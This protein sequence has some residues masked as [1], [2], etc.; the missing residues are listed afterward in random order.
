[1]IAQTRIV[2]MDQMKH[3]REHMA[4]ALPGGDILLIVPPFT[5]NTPVI[6]PHILQAIARERGYQADIA[7]ASMLLA[8]IIGW[9][10]AEQLATAQVMQ[11]WTMITERL[12][13]RRAYGLPPLGKSPEACASEALSITGNLAQHRRADYDSA[14]LDLARFGEIEAICFAFVDEVV[15]AIAALPYTLIGCTARMGQ[16][17]C[18]VA[19]LDG[20]KRLRPDV[21]TLIG[22]ASCQNEMAAGVASLSASIDYIFS[23]ESEGIFAEFLDAYACG[24]LP[25]ERILY[26]QPLETLETQPIIDYDSYFAQMR[27][28]LG[29]DAPQRPLIWYETSRGCWWGQRQKCTFCGRNYQNIAFRPK[30]PSKVLDDL[31]ALK[32]RYPDSPI[33]MTD[34]IMP[35][36][37]PNDLLPALAQSRAYPEIA[38]YYVKANLSLN[39]LRRLKQARVATVIPGLE[40]LSTGLLRLLNKGVTARQNVSFLRNARAVGL[41]LTWF[42]LWGIPG[43][44][45]ECYQEVLRLLPLIRH[46]QPPV[47][48]LSVQ[49]ERNSAY[50]N[51]PA[52]HTITNLRPWAVYDMIYPEWADIDKLASFFTGDYACAADEHPELIQQIADELTRWRSAWKTARLTMRPFADYYMIYDSREPGANTTYVVEDESRAKALM[53]CCR[54]TESAHQQWAVEQRLGT[55]VDDWYVPL[56]TAAPDVVAEFEDEYRRA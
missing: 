47:K 52:A 5:T 3:V 7:Y 19:L 34:D 1:M 23:G 25:A 32:N 46:L 49:L 28:F 13:A 48:F 31:R 54:Y 43:D 16:V 2:E 30:S 15:Q 29:A 38:L 27:A 41:N 44:S 33:A 12:F 20:I 21:I 56:V 8:A 9:Q 35:A 24:R 26:G 42:M 45:A 14:E 40:A 22:G 18:S 36:S 37:Y 55:V 17:N 10:F 51:D 4:S 11:Y 50:V 53:T 39:D 6:G